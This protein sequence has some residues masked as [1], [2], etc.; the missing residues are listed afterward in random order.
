[1]AELMLGRDEDFP[2]SLGFAGDTMNTALYL[3]RLLPSSV[4]VSYISVLG[5][6]P[7]SE[8]LIKRLEAE[9]IS[10]NRIERSPTR[11][12]GLYSISTDAKGE[13]SFNYWR[14][15]SAARTLFQSSDS[16]V[17]DSLDEVDVVY[18]SAI[19]L[20]ILP[21]AVRAAFLQELAE[22]RKTKNVTVVFDSNYRP[23]L[24]ESIDTA[25][26]C[27]SS[28]WQITDIALPSVDDEQ[29]LFGDTNENAVV[30]R[31]NGYGVRKGALK[32]GDNGPRSLDP[33][34]SAANF[35]IKPA[36]TPI[37]VVDTTAAG[38]SFN[39][40]YLSEYLLNENESAALHAGHDCAMRVIAHSGAIIPKELW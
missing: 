34:S 11:Q 32:R 3:K 18:F 16:M 30:D 19:T 22:L 24:W 37:K 10:T 26:E 25:R 38:D 36:S 1:M 39:A 8:R 13:R 6:D 17:F 29:A 28:A 2:P 33:E 12:I 15:E 20:A 23:A 40:G 21:A 27:I 31:L 9:S 14:N 5:T 35:R 7:L 4:D